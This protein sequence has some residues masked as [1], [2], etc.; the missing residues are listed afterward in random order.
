[1]CML[2]VSVFVMVAAHRREEPIPEKLTQ[3][4]MKSRQH[5]E[6]WLGG[7][8]A[9]GGGVLR[10]HEEYMALDTYEQAHDVKDCVWSAGTELAAV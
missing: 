5:V 9:A 4:A 10:E 7:V 1:M 3:L 6:S 2:Y 8:R